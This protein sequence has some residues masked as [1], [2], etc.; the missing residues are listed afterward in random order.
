MTFLQPIYDLTPARNE[1]DN[2]ESENTEDEPDNG[3]LL[4]IW[5]FCNK[6]QEHISIFL[7][8]QKNM[9]YRK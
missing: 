8:I 6:L 2:T 1:F 9:F 5:T 7:F 3:L 4:L